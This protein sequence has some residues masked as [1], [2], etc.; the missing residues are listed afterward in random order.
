MFP[1]LNLEAHRFMILRKEGL[2]IFFPQA[3]PVFIFFT[4]TPNVSYSQLMNAPPLG[5]SV[6]R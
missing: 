5:T 6:I 4:L 1:R 2:T 3:K